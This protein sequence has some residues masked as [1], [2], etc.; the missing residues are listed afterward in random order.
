MRSRIIFIGDLHRAGQI[1]NIEK[2]EMLFSS[3]FYNININVEHIISEMNSLEENM[4]N[5][6]VWSEISTENLVTDLSNINFDSAS[7]IG[8]ELP[9]FYLNFM[10]NLGVP[11]VNLHIHPLRFLDDLCF[12]VS[13]S[14]EYDHVFNRINSN[15]INYNVN[16]M[17]IGLDI[18]KREKS[19]RKTL[20]ILGQSPFDKSVWFDNE[21]KNL[22]HYTDKIDEIA[23]DCQEIFYRPHPYMSDKYVD[24]MICKKYNALILNE[25]N[26]Y[27]LLLEKDIN[28]VCAISSSSVLEARYFDISGIYLEERAKTYGMPIAYDLILSDITFWYEKLLEKDIGTIQIEPILSERGIVREAFG[29]W[30]YFDNNRRTKNEIRNIN[31]KIDELYIK[32]KELYNSMYAALEK[33]YSSR[34]WKWTKP[35][36]FFSKILKRKNS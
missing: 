26:Y 2:I 10:T 17:K 36:R 22:L 6:K 18:V 31:I 32:N 28:I 16:K 11:W 29:Y 19:N 5:I 27:Q 3:L 35:L 8:F 30:S 24:D 1:A 9:H 15:Q 7:V 25:E 21:F 12:S 34:S 23:C 20:L 13:S 33:I 14:F 4:S